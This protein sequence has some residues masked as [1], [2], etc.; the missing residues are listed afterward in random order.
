MA[1]VFGTRLAGPGRTSRYDPGAAPDATW[2]TVNGVA[3]P[4]RPEEPDNC[5]MSGC[6]HCVWDDYRDELEEWA[7]RLAQA[8]AKS[9][10]ASDGKDQRQTPRAEVNAASGS[11]DDDGGGSETNWTL[12]DPNEDLFANI[13]V[14]IREF[15]KTE[16]KLR[17]RHQAE[18]HTTSGCLESVHK[19][20][21]QLH[22]PS[23]LNGH[24]AWPP[25]PLLHHGMSI[26]KSQ[27]DIILNKA[28]VALARSQRLVASWLPA[29]TAADQANV[30]SEEELQRE[31]DEIFTAVPE[32][33]GV[34]APLPTKAADGSWN[35]TELDSNDKLRK[36]LL[37]R[38]Y[39]KV[40]AAKVHAKPGAPSAGVATG[41][42]SAKAASSGAGQGV[43]EEDE[44]E[45][46]GRL[47]LIGRKNAS[48]RKRKVN[49]HTLQSPEETESMDLEAKETTAGV[50]GNVSKQKED[51][52][53]FSSGR[54]S[55]KKGT[56]FLDEILAERSKKRKKR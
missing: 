29:P 9:S 27:T 10:P 44:D 17:Q 42:P 49:I 2:K 4:P 38:N 31:E 5:C 12:P 50:D 53:Q 21:R 1:I 19:T 11:M 33:L 8:K 32:T 54:R 55:R 30:K 23:S 14:G 13:P 48:S 22:T 26:S 25:S 6:V 7:A 37:G 34:G 35:R 41:R 20:E 43:D 45:E 46:E 56:S 24:F 40:M 16:K 3:I 51:S 39:Q 52:S 18:V 36:Q 15:M 28:N 47:A